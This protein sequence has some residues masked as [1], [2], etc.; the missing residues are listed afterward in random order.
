MMQFDEMQ[1][2]KNAV[3]SRCRKYRYVLRRSWQLDLPQVLFVAL[4]P[5]TADESTD[6]ATVRRCVGFGRDWGFGGIV[7]A[8]LFAYRSSDPAA[9]RTAKNP[10]GPKNDRW[11]E[12][13]SGE[14]GITV[15]AWGAH[16][17][18]NGR[19]EIVLPKLKNVHV[20]GRTQGGD[21]RHPLYLRRSA[22]PIR[23]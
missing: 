19:A 8:N 5:S 6:D 20:L 10:V 13:L 12:S 15:A 18:L 23:L 9:L 11:L 7:I 14:A 4:N 16:G 17:N 1:T 21:P 22:V 2:V 3:F